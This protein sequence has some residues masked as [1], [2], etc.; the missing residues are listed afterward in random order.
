MLQKRKRKIREKKNLL[1]FDVPL[2]FEKDNINNKNLNGIQNITLIVVA[3][4]LSTIK[5]FDEILYIDAG[6][7]IEK[8]SHKNLMRKKGSYYQLYQ[9]QLKKNA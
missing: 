3:H 8:G 4:R 9:K 5:N 2:L 6:K 1:V 7:L